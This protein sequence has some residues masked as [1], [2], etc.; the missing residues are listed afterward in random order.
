VGYFLPGN[1]KSFPP[2]KPPPFPTNEIAV[3]LGMS[4]NKL[5]KVFEGAESESALH[6]ADFLLVE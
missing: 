2:P 6:S 4:E 1:F 5:L 3:F